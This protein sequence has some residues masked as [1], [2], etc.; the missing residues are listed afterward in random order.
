MK[1][2]IISLFV[3]LFSASV[4]TA[5]EP[6]SEFKKYFPE[7]L[8]YNECINKLKA[9]GKLP[10]KDSK[11]KTNSIKAKTSK[12]LEIVKDKTGKILEKLNTHSTLTDWI[13]KNK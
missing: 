12:N 6:C 13:K 2:I 5:E 10:I 11:N 9:E 3:I 1:K 7:V 4:N 8:K